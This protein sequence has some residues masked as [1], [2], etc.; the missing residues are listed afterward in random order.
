MICASD[1]FFR[2][3]QSTFQYGLYLTAFIENRY[4]NNKTMRV[5]LKNGT[6]I[7]RGFECLK[8]FN[9]Q[10]RG[11]LDL[12]NVHLECHWMLTMKNLNF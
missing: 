3:T 12:D 8:A 5:N 4:A 7:F 10:L 6:I 11:V 1:V 2:F 9:A